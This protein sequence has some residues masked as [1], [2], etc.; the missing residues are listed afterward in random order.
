M[1]ERCGVEEFDSGTGRD[2]GF[3]VAVV[4]AA[5]QQEDERAKSLTTSA[6]KTGDEIRDNREIDSGDRQNSIFNQVEICMHRGADVARPDTHC[7]NSG[8]HASHNGFRATEQPIRREY[9][10]GAMRQ[11][12]WRC[13]I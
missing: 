12:L 2:Q 1:D 3:E 11:P 6:D 4:A 10:W 8:W 9:K 13:P 5:G 7:S